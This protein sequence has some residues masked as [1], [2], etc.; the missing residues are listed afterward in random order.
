[1]FKCLP[2]IGCSTNRQ[3]EK[4][5]KSHCDLHEVPEEI[6]RAYK[7]LEECILDANHLPSLPK[8][9]YSTHDMMD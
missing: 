5:D 3:V 8:V 1:M 7:T 9:Q 2:I 6:L 4:L